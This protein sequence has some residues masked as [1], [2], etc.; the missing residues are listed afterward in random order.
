MHTFNTDA[1]I[2]HG[3]ELHLHH[4][5]FNDGEKVKV[6]VIAPNEDQEET[7]RR[8]EYEEFMKGYADEDSI[9]DNI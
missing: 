3:G 6:I 7:I 9:Y 1:T 8:F 5:P 2:I 4:L